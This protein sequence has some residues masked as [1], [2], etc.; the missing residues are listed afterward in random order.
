MSTQDNEAE[1]KSLEQRLTGIQPM[2]EDAVLEYTQ[3]V[4]Q[5]IVSSLIQNGFV[6]GDNS[7]RNMLLSALDGLDRQALTNK[8]I[9]AD[10]E[11]ARGMNN[12]AGLVA[13]VLAAVGRSS[14]E[15]V[16][17]NRDAPVLG[18]EI[19]EPQLVPGELDQN[20]EQMNYESFIASRPAKGADDQPSV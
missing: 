16:V 19:P 15:I 8:R 4:R 9:K 12:A 20:P 11:N 14:R 2:A 18:S 6:P 1:K 3:K 7:D 13:Q 5:G 10:Q 17:V